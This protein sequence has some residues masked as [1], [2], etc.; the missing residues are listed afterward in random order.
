MKTI[1]VTKIIVNTSTFSVY[2][3]LILNGSTIKPF[4]KNIIVL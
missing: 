1:L 4:V 3:L 2:N